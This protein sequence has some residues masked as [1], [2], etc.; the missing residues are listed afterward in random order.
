MPEAA[1]GRPLSGAPRAG[2]YQWS[3]DLVLDVTEGVE[4]RFPDGPFRAPF[5]RRRRPRHRA[6]AGACTPL[7]A[8]TEP[9]EQELSAP[10]STPPKG[11]NE[12]RT[13]PK[14]RPPLGKS[15]KGVER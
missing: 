3:G 7:R 12:Y 15:H 13:T 14:E 6:A 11:P 9:P 1:A 10:P 8:A 2:V 5:R 4:R